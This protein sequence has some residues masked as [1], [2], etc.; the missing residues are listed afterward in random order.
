MKGEYRMAP[1]SMLVTQQNTPN[2]A[3]AAFVQLAFDANYGLAGGAAPHH[4][5]KTGPQVP[6]EV[7]AELDRKTDDG[8]PYD[9]LLQFSAYAANGASGPAE[10]GPTACTPAIS[11]GAPWN[12][13]A[14][15]AD[16]GAALVL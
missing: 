2:N 12:I 13:S 15:S 8:K 6:I 9:G 16:C 4:N 14:G 7:V 1:G 11:A 10:G 3:Y 5:L